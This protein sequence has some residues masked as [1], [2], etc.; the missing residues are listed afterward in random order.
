[1]NE[2]TKTVLLGSIKKWK[3]IEDGTGEDLGPANCSLCKVFRIGEGCDFCPVRE[4]TGQDYCAE[5][6]YREWTEHQ[7]S[8]HDAE[9]LIVMKVYCST[10]AELAKEE[11]EFLESLLV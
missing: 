10:C 6:P 8:V 7:F 4:K 5:S 9:S 11:R 2:E 1:M 3:D